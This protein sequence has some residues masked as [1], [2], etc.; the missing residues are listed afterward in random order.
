MA[1]RQGLTLTKSR[2]RDSRAYDF[3]GYMLIDSHTS[4][5]VLGGSPFAYSASLDDVEDYLTR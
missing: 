3:G 5:L 4:G 1:E 2:R